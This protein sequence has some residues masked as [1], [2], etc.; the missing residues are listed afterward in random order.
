MTAFILKDCIKVAQSLANAFHYLSHFENIQEWDPGVNWCRPI[1]LAEPRIGSE[2]LLSFRTGLTS[3]ELRYRIIELDPGKLI[4]LEGIGA[5]FKAID[6]IE[7]LPA[8]EGCKINYAAH[9]TLDTN[10]PKPI[11]QPVMQ[12]IGKRAMSGLKR[13]LSAPVQ[14]HRLS[15]GSTLEDRLIAPGVANYSAIGWHRHK[16]YFQGPMPSIADK[17]VLITGATSGLGLSVAERLASNGANLLLVGRDQQ[18]LEAVRS[19]FKKRGATTQIEL[20]KADLSRPS[21]LPKLVEAVQTKTD[22]LHALINNAGILNDQFRVNDAGIEESTYVNLFAPY[23]L[24]HALRAFLKRD[25][26]PRIVNVS[27]G[28]MYTQ[29]LAMQALKNPRSAD[30]DGTVAY[31]Q[32]KRGLVI[33]TEEL[34]KDPEFAGIGIHAMHPGWV[35]TPGVRSSLPRFYKATKGIL[36]TSEQGSDT[37]NWLAAAPASTLGS[38][39]FWFD[40][41]P[42]SAYLI[43]GTKE[44]ASDREAL[45]KY[46]AEKFP[47]V[48]DAQL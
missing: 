32:A 21:D 3:L 26:E 44:P 11:L 10:L 17:W 1:T 2:Y 37:I 15:M 22:R 12:I 47:S 46:L 31:A 43:P 28:G 18:K 34:A 5:G 16:P 19:D 41:S 29:R 23:Y 45:L 6:E 38:G 14:S 20:L 7:F 24:M 33:L 4:K 25:N 8:D 48:K 9:I 13:A 42:R 39:Q 30:F 40:R 36:R 27:S 35:D